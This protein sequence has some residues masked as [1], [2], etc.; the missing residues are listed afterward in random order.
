MS[1]RYRRRQPPLQKS[2]VGASNETI[3]ACRFQAPMGTINACESYINF[4]Q[5]AVG[6]LCRIAQFRSAP[7]HLRPHRPVRPHSLAGDRR[8][9]SRGRGSR[10]GRSASSRTAVSL[11][12]LVRG[13]RNV[14]DVDCT[15]HEVEIA[16][17]A[18]EATR[19]HIECSL[20][21]SCRT[22]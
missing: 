10:F 11:H 12:Q 1:I 9:H 3:A 20:G 22:M 4:C 16:A 2:S 6:S 5:R 18:V 14:F 7:R 21:P 15:F 13:H 17:A 19:L 8:S